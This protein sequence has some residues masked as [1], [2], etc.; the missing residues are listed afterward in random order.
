MAHATAS[1]RA[2][3]IVPVVD[4]VV[5]DSVFKNAN[6]LRLLPRIDAAGTTYIVKAK[7]ASNSSAAAYAEGDAAPTVQ[8]I[9]V[10]EGSFSYR[11]WWVSYGETGHARRQRGPNWDGTYGSS[12]AELMDALGQLRDVMETDSLA[13]AT[14]GLL[15]QVDD[16]STTWGGLN[17]G[18]YTALKSLVVAGGSAEN[19][20]KN[21]TYLTLGVREAPYGGRPNLILSAPLQIQHYMDHLCSAPVPTFG[22]QIAD[23]GFSGA[24][25]AGIP[26]LA[27]PDFVNSEIAAIMVDPDPIISDVCYVNHELEGAEMTADGASPGQVA[28]LQLGN[29]DDSVNYLANTAGALVVRRPQRC[30]KIEALAT[31]WT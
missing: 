1:S 22:G 8:T 5:V 20:N 10:M 29:T 7:T 27:I 6:F 30:A 21:L 19:T 13:D 11:S 14:Y 17:R 9:T 4:P 16:D 24:S 31:S 18:T 28:F 25:Y 15:G 2:N 26:W 23:R 12:D 3:L